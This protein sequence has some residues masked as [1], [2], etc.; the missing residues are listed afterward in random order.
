M[1]SFSVSV[2]YLFSPTCILK[3]GFFAALDRLGVSSLLSVHILSD[4]QHKLRWGILYS[5]MESVPSPIILLCT[6]ISSCQIHPPH[7]HNIASLLTWSSR[8][9]I[10]TH[11][12]SMIIRPGVNG[13]A[14]FPS[15]GALI[16]FLVNFYQEKLYTFVCLRATLSSI[17]TNVT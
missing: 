6:L 8:L 3:F 5:Q 10:S 11:L 17:V 7:F 14:E 15:I 12:V 9:G 1:A 13:L 2:C 16:G 4:S